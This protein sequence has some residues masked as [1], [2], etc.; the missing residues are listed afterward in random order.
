MHI[1]FLA[2]WY[3]NLCPWDAERH[4][5][6]R[7]MEK[8]PAFLGRANLASRAASLSHLTIVTT[9][10]VVVMVDRPPHPCQLP[11]KWFSH[12]DHMTPGGHTLVMWYFTVSTLICSYV[13]CRICSN[14]STVLGWGK[15]NCSRDVGFSLHLLCSNLKYW[16][17]SHGKLLICWSSNHWF[18]SPASDAIAHDFC[19]LFQVKEDASWTSG[20]PKWQSDGFKQGKSYRISFVFSLT[21]RC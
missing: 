16:C 14:E 11:I 12:L 4:S 6:R 15:T 10:I 5:A 7:V 8:R 3:R 1:V 13:S 21:K 19:F 17:V 18:Q 2:T 20:A 9:V